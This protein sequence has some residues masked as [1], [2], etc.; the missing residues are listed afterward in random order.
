[1]VSYRRRRRF[2]GRRRFRSFSRKGK[3]TYRRSSN[4]KRV[5]KIA[6]R[7]ALSLNETK[8]NSLPGFSTSIST[9][10]Y[11]IEIFN[12]AQGTGPSDRIG[13]SIIPQYLYSRCGMAVSGATET[14]DIG[15]DIYNW[16]RIVVW[17]F[18]NNYNDAIPDLTGISVLTPFR[19]STFSNGLN[20]PGLQVH[21]DKLKL[22]KSNQYVKEDGTLTYAPS[23]LRW[24]FR[25]KFGK[26]SKIWA[27]QNGYVGQT[28]R[29]FISFLS[30]SSLPPSPS[31][32]GSIYWT[33]KDNA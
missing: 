30:D 5:Y 28:R 11:N 20:A 15:D 27:K 14:L 21:Y 4:T 33:W 1:M 22:I 9:S 23:R 18:N 31:W 24:D 29:Y 32:S 10:G 17:S 13:N 2:A 12:P 8:G 6:K 19:H 16:V 26:R 3:R 7:A 25:C